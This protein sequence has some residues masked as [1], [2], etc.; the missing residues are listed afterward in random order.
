MQAQKISNT[1]TIPYAKASMAMDLGE[2][3]GDLAGIRMLGFREGHQY[4]HLVPYPEQAHAPVLE[5]VQEFATW[6]SVPEEQG[7]FIVGPSGVGKTTGV[8][9]LLA[10][11]NVP[12][13]KVGCH[14]DMTLLELIGNSQLKEKNG[15]SVSEFVYGPLAQAFKYGFTIVLEEMNLMFPDVLAG[16]NEIVRGQT[17]LVEQTGE[18]IRRHPA[19]RIIAAGNSFGNGDAG[20]GKMHG[21]KAQNAAFLNRWWKFSMGFLDVQQEYNILKDKTQKVP[22]E[23]LRGIINVAESIRDRSI[24]RNPGDQNALDLEFGTRTTITWAQTIDRFAR[25]G[26][27]GSIKRALHAT[28]LRAEPVEIQELLDQLCT[29][30]FGADY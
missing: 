9:H 28:M 13:L 10:E 4:Q 29:N 12:T 19:F 21:A 11:A 2:I 23:I 26:M 16:I 24:Y 6:F 25:A 17:L 7:F 18:V 14:R 27:G 15:A 22:P 5:F 8:L 30:E 20:S 1:Q 3:S